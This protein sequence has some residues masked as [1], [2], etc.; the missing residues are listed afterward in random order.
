MAT[1]AT[2][3]YRV[4][5]YFVI[6]IGALFAALFVY[7]FV[8]RHP[9][10]TLHAFV[11]PSNSFCPP[12]CKG[13][14][15]LVQMQMGSPYSPRRGDVI[16]FR[17]G[18]DDTN[19]IKRLIGMPGDLVGP[20]PGNTILVNGQAWQPPSICAKSLLGADSGDS[21]ISFQPARV[22]EGQMF[23]IGDNLTNSYDSR[24]DE[25]G[26][27][28]PVQVVGKPVMIYWSPSGARIGCPIK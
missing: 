13:E 21:P 5:I 28:R 3:K 11:V 23:V 19:F 1:G 25:F 10:W 22:A 7:H 16:V 6:T 14:R 18:P 12:I 24:F 15:V 8:Y 4:G 2:W 27:V 20:G 26:E 17:H 9:Y